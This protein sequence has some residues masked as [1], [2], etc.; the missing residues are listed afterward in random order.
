MLNNLYF[1]LTKEPTLFEE[2][3]EYFVQKYFTVDLPYL[4]NFTIKSGGLVSLQGIVVGILET[5][6]SPLCNGF[7]TPEF[8]PLYLQGT[9]TIYLNFEIIKSLPTI[10]GKRKAQFLTPNIGKPEETLRIPK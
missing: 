5:K 1:T 2:L 4:E 8:P 10:P 6:A 3:W 7:N 9:V